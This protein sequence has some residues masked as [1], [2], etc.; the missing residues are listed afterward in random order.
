MS[1]IENPIVFIPKL[2]KDE[3][4]LPLTVVDGYKLKDYYYISNY[5]R[6]YSIYSGKFLAKELGTD[7][8][9]IMPLAIVGGHRNF[10]VSRL[11]MCTFKYFFGCEDYIVNHKDCMPDAE[12]ADRLD[13]LEWCTYSTNLKH[14]YANGLRKAKSGAE[15]V[16]STISENQAEEICKLISQG[17]NLGLIAEMMNV[18]PSVV[19]NISA[20]RAWTEI[21]SKYNFPIRKRKLK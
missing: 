14:A 1:K 13:N 4:F 19:Y 10:R 20:K 15:S 21:S 16:F 6:I 12:F 7:N 5:G 18:N 17:I 9:W 11:V 3:V 8:H 2:F